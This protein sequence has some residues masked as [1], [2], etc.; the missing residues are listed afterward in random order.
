M[1]GAAEKVYANALF[2]LS[3]ESD[4][5]EKIYGELGF[6]SDVFND[7]PKLSKIL[8]VPTVTGDEKQ[9]L[10]LDIFGE[11]LSELSFNFL[12]VLVLHGKIMFISRIYLEYKSR[13]YSRKGIIEIKA[14]TAVKLKKTLRDKL[15]KKL[16]SISSKTVI[17]VEEIDASIIGGIVLSYGNTQIDSSIKSRIDSMR[18][19]INSIIA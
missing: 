3:V 17:L 12:N 10:I 1:T 16:E 9:K 14:T 5:V 13:Y 15:I 6:L 2:E 8:S 4:S 11:K 19:Q 7:N 18:K